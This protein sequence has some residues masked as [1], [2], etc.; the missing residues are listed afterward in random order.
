EAAAGQELRHF[1]AH[2]FPDDAHQ[3]VYCVAASPDGRFVALGGQLSYV[4][5]HDVATGKEVKRL[6]GPSGAVSSLAFSADG[7]TLA[8]GDWTGGAIHLWEVATGQ[9][10]RRLVG[11]QGRAFHLAFSADGSLLVTGNGDTTALVW[12]L[13]GRH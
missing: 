3:R 5:L 4:V 2:R 8:G 6:T 10:F 1:A 9:R 12:D 11:H 7:R 13:T